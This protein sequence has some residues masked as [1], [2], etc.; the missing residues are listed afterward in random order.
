MPTY[1]RAFCIKNAINSLLKQTY[2]KFELIIVDDGSVDGTEQIVKTI[3]KKYIS[4]KKIKYIKL[5]H[6]GVCAARNIGLYTAKN[7][8]ITY[9]DT[10]NV[11]LSNALGV[12]AHSIMNNPNQEN[13]YGKFV[14]KT[15]KE[16]YGKPF[17]FNDIK[18]QN[19]IDLGTYVHN[20]HLV[21]I[22]GVFDEDL[23]RFVD[24]EMIARHCAYSH[25]KF[26]DNVVMEYNDSI[27]INRITTSENY[28]QTYQRAYDKISKLKKISK[29][30]TSEND[31]KPALS[32]INKQEEIIDSCFF[33]IVIPNYNNMPYIQKCLDSILNQSFQD[34]KIVIVD[35]LSTDGSDKFC[36]MYS[37]KYPDKIV[38][39][40]MK[41]KGHE[42]GARNMGIN[43][44]K[45]LSR[46]TYFVDGDDMLYNNNVL[47][48]L[49]NNLKDTD[50][51]I[52]LFNM[53]QLIGNQYVQHGN[54]NEIFVKDSRNNALTK[55]NSASSKAVKST[56]ITP[57]LENCDHGADAY[58]FITLLDK[59]P[60]I[61]QIND[62]IYTYRRNPQSLTMT[63]NNTRYADDTQLFYM[64]LSLLMT[65][66]KTESVRTAV[67]YRIKLFNEG[68]IKR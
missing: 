52:L 47:Q 9:L 23:V 20:R 63:T 16:V 8:W 38:L 41:D 32:A 51:D 37:R 14:S 64:K 67:L 40:K 46:Y 53:I 48:I 62:I 61:K 30:Q 35:D 54:K 21:D 11:L 55:W 33:K 10:D 44:K 42:G 25:P 36:E 13:F 65:K 2:Q 7:D 66:L 6:H 19:T 26:I 15:T 31:V 56:F 27:Q 17:T 59:N 60:K 58:Q 12:Y 3:F 28:A 50:L 57:F 68:I 5:D 1:N 45:I 24:W 22:C 43:Y 4:N 29:I 18:T 34:F 49:Y 39:L